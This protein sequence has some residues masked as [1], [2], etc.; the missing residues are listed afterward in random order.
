MRSKQEFF[1]FSLENTK[2]EEN[3]KGEGE[4]NEDETMVQGESHH[5]RCR[6]CE[7]GDKNLGK[8]IKNAPWTPHDALFQFF[9]FLI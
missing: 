1:D 3:L 4:T 5:F 8:F 6:Y 2:M 9:L 7:G